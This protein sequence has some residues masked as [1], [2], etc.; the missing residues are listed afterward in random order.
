MSGASDLP[1]S[2]RKSRAVLG[3]AKRSFLERGF[4]ATNLDEVASAAGVS[5]MTIYSHFGSKERLF[6]AVLEAVIAERS[7][8]GPALDADIDEA[9]LDEALTAIAADLVETVQDAEVV[10]LRRVLVAEQP[11]QP[12][13]ASAWR[14]STVLAA[15]DALADYF[16][17]LQRRGL[18]AEVDP[19]VLATQFLW[20]LIGDPL[21]ARLLDPQAPR[22]AA[23]AQAQEVV[24]TVLSAYGRRTD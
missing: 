2:Q 10:G 21:D 15:V 16:G 3:A 18:L 17:A 6:I 12:G 7:G 19:T 11:R 4:T 13:L 1:A 20:M 9:G 22:P 23:D 24:R 5:K 14:R 8:S